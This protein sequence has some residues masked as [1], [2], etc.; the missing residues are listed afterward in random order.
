MQPITVRTARTA[1]GIVGP[2]R[3][4]AML[5]GVQT[6]PKG[7][8]IARPVGALPRLARFRWAAGAFPYFPTL[9][10]EQPLLPSQRL[11]RHQ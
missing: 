8:F 2:G 10:S 6:G 1:A 4:E 9:P 5:V 11:R 7:L 3:L